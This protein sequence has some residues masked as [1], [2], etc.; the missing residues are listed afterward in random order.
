MTISRIMK[1]VWARAFGVGIVPAIWA[2]T[3]RPAA[4]GR[5]KP[6]AP[7]ART[8]ALTKASTPICEPPGDRPAAGD[9]EVE[10]SPDQDAVLVRY[11]ATPR[12]APCETL[13]IL[14]R[15]RSGMLIGDP[16]GQMELVWTAQREIEDD[17]RVSF[18]VGSTPVAVSSELKR[19]GLRVEVSTRAPVSVVARYGSEPVPT[20]VIS[21]RRVELSTRQTAH[22]QS[23]LRHLPFYPI[24]RARPRA[25]QQEATARVP[26]GSDPA[27]GRGWFCVEA[28]S[29]DEPK[30]RISSCH[31]T[32]AECEESRASIRVMESRV[33]DCIS[34]SAAECYSWRTSSGSG[35]SC[36]YRPSQCNREATSRREK[37]GSS[38][39][40]SGCYRAD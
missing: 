33:G 1:S 11:S 31:R 13:D 37:E 40:T 36:F 16:S 12:D 6:A 3:P 10:E 8:L 34:S 14:F 19:H 26:T 39:Q 29:R 22:L 35:R 28:Q 30:K 38:V 4:S 17:A 2:C 5:V 9:A 32:A 20:L 18:L 7:P 15:M 27:S 23:F 21:D 25:D 24:A